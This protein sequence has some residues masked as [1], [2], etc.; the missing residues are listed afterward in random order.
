MT[1]KGTKKRIIWVQNANSRFFESAYF[2][3]RPGAAEMAGEDDM[4]LEAERI[5]SEAQRN[6]FS[7]GR[8]KRRRPFLGGL[9]TGVGASSLLFAIASLIYLLTP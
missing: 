7:T 1:N 9:L 5:V 3:L 4:I 6:N 8:K 2:I